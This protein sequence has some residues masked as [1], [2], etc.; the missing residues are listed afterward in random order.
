MLIGRISN[1]MNKRGYTLLEVILF[2]AITTGLAVIAFAGLGPRVRNARFTDSMRSLESNIASNLGS[3][4]SGKNTR[5]KISSC[6]ENDGLIK[7]T[8]E[9]TTGIVAGS[10]E[11]CVINGVAAVLNN[12]NSIQYRQLVSL[13]ERKLGCTSPPSANL[14]EPSD[15][16]LD[17]IKCYRTTMLGPEA[18]SSVIY[19]YQNGMRRVSSTA[20]STTFAVLQHPE[21]GKTYRLEAVP[22]NSANGSLFSSFQ[23]KTD[24]NHEFD[25]IYCL[26]SRV[27]TLRFSNSKDVPK[28]LMNE[29]AGC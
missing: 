2:L 4:A 9:Q 19:S 13:R 28:L 3:V 8:E 26:N 14:G 6:I 7:V 12:D 23:H 22:I 27:A 15:P 21:T 18:S 11:N 25:S 20:N 16:V 5:V 17:L 24:I 1:G 29:G 10:S